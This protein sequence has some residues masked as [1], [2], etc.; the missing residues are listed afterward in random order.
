MLCWEAD[1]IVLPPFNTA[2]LEDWRTFTFA[3]Q[4]SPFPSYRLYNALLNWI[5]AG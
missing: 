1:V 3:L 5:Q 4:I 2:F